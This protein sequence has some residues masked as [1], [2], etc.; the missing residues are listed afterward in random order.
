MYHKN[1]YILDFTCKNLNK[2][3]KNVCLAC[4]RK[5]NKIIKKNG[6]K[7]NKKILNSVNNISR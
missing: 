2:L 7:L 5:V 6:L 4:G 1:T 3:R